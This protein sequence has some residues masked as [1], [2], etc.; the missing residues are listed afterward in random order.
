[1]FHHRMGGSVMETAIEGF[2]HI[3]SLINIMLQ[4]RKVGELF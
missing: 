2:S 4:S 1:M 3:K